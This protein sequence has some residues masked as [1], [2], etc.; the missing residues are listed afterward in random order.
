MPYRNSFS[1]AGDET[2]TQL[3]SSVWLC[4]LGLPQNHVTSLGLYLSDAF[5]YFS[6]FRSVKVPLVPLISK[7]FLW[8]L[9]YSKGFE[10]ESL[11]RH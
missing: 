6:L 2:L 7:T 10:A 11:P 5:L 4:H 8:F 9:S 3:L 1:S